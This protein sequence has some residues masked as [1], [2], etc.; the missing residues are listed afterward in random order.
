MKEK[1]YC[2]AIHGGAGTLLRDQMGAKEEKKYRAALAKALSKG[3]DILKLGG[4]ALDAVT[5][6]VVSLED[7]PLFNAGKG[8]VFTSK[9]TQEMDASIMDGKS[10]DAGAVAMV[11]RIKNP[12]LLAR[13][14]MEKSEHLM[15]AGR[16]AEKFA[17]QNGIKFMPDAY[18]FTEHRYK[19]L[20]VAKQNKEI[21]LDHDH[22][23]F[24]TVGAVALDLDGNL[25]A[26]TSTGGMTNKKFGRIGDTPIVGSGTW[27]DNSSCAVSCT[28]SGEYFMRM[29][30]AFHVACI[31]KY[32][33]LGLERAVRKVIHELLP[34]ING[35]GGLIAVDSRGNLCL[36]FNTEGMY[37]AYQKND[38]EAVIAIFKDV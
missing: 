29:N 21:L 26:A 28:G 12:V 11:R 7:C 22:R 14:V 17:K 31:M 2:I 27:A 30:V 19:Q 3:H 33:K 23:K 8:S 13:T 25:A 4:N 10:L 24:G 9:G 6:S 35:D 5:A 38:D 16:G 18:F 32:G 36:D 34:T 1:N 15:L 37:R 20:L